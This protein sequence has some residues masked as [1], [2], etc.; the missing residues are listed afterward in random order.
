MYV[1]NNNKNSVFLLNSLLHPDE[2]DVVALVNFIQLHKLNFAITI[3]L[4]IPIINELRFLRHPRY[5]HWS[6]RRNFVYHQ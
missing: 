3:E 6:T 1:I 2:E 5:A 4:N